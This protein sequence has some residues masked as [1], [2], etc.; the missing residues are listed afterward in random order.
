VISIRNI[1][2]TDAGEM[3]RWRNSSL[4]RMNSL[5][6][7]VISAEEHAC[8]VS[9]SIS[10]K[11]RQTY[12]VC[13]EE[14]DIG[15]VSFKKINTFSEVSIYLSPDYIGHGYGSKALERGIEFFLN[16]NPEIRVVSATILEGNEPSIKTFE[17]CGF[18]RKS[19]NYEFVV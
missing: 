13:L 11:D 19:I 5:N 9:D 18:N 8:W 4:V 12:M 6:N 15:I 3:L 16:H 14:A 7:K 2:L 10:N 17:K 1:S